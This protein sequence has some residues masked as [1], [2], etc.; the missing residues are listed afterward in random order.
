M[1]LLFVYRLRFSTWAQKL[2]RFRGQQN[3]HRRSGLLNK[4][5]IQNNI[6]V[7]SLYTV[8]LNPRPAWQENSYY[9]TAVSVYRSSTV[10]AINNVTLEYYIFV[11]YTKL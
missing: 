3:K 5:K 8:N 11:Y 7:M 4:K 10:Y 9:C 2:Q 1:H 6:F